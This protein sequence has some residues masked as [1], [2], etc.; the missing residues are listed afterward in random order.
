MLVTAAEFDALLQN[1]SLR[2][3]MIGMSNVGKT[4]RAKSL[5]AD[6]ALN[7]LWVCCD[8]LVEAKLKPFLE[9][10]GF[11][12]VDGVAAWMG[13]PYE[14]RYPETQSLFLKFEEEV[15]AEIDYQGSKNIIIDTTG[16]VIYLSAKALRQL[17]GSA[18]IVYLEASEDIKKF[19][20]ERYMSNP[21]PVVW[22]GSFSKKAGESDME[23]LKRCYP[24]L[25]EFRA[26]KYAELADLTI[27]YLALRDT[28]GKQFL[29][30]VRKRLPSS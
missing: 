26:A 2:I 23:A 22:G 1:N 9:G 11:K 27:P 21:K 19:L 12:G 25:L 8:D 4:K 24:Q 5:V 15:M 6:S 17:R 28:S 18:L 16:S 3:T 20:F 14:Q 10:K 30:E 7:F 29:D 13:Q